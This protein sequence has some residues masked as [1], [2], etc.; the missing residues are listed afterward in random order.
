MANIFENTG[1]KVT[2]EYYVNNAGSQITILG[3]S[4]FK[5]YQELHGKKINIDKTEY[6]G[7]YLIKI[8]EKIYSKYKNKWL[9]I[10]EDKKNPR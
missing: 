2:R 7:D 6:P 9:N 10:E 3:K 1:H 5:R 4:L 8:A